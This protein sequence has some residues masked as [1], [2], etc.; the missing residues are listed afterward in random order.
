MLCLLLVLVASGRAQAERLPIKSFTTVN[1][2][3]HDRVRRI[4]RDSRGFLWFCTLEGLSRFDGYRFTNYDIKDG[5]PINSCQDLL[6][7]RQGEYWVATDRGV[8]RFNPLASPGPE[9]GQGATTSRFT[10]YPLSEDLVSNHANNLYEDSAGRIWACSV[11]GLF[12]MDRAQGK[13]AFER[14]MLDIPVVLSRTRAVQDVLEDQEGSLWIITDFGLHRRL[15][16]GR[17]VRYQDFYPGA[18]MMD[19]N[20]ALWMSTFGELFLFRPTPAAGYAAGDPSPW[21]VLREHRSSVWRDASLPFSPAQGEAIR[22]STTEGFI[23]GSIRALRQSADGSIWFGQDNRDSGGIFHFSGKRFTSY[24]TDKGLSNNVI[25]SLDEDHAGNLWIGTYSNGAMKLSRN[26]FLTF[27]DPARLNQMW[28]NSIFEDSS[29]NFYAVTYRYFVNRLENDNFVAQQPGIPDLAKNVGWGWHHGMLQDHLGEWWVNTLI[30]LYRFPRVKRI[31]ELAKLSPKAFY[32]SKNG[33]PDDNIFTLFED[34]RGDIWI[35]TFV[36][37]ESRLVRWERATEQFHRYTVA[38]GLPPQNSPY[39]FCEDGSGN[40][41]IGFFEGGIARYQG[42]RFTFFGEAEGVPGGAIAGL[43]V[44]RLKGLW[45]AS[46]QGG[47]S[48]MADPN[49]EQM[50]LQTYTVADGLA[51]NNIRCITEDQWGR[52]YVGVGSGVDRLDPASGSVTHYTT[53]DG[54]ASSFVTTAYRDR[55]NRLWFGTL[56]GLSMLVPS[57]EQL[58]SSLP[59]LINGLRVAGVTFPVSDLGEVAVSPQEFTAAQNQIEIDFF[60]LSLVTGE[61]LRYQFKLEGSDED[62]KPLTEQR[63]VNY[64]SLSPGSYRFVVRAVNG[65]GV[66]SQSPASFGFRILPPFWRRWW[67]VTLIATLVAASIFAIDRYREGRLRAIKESEDRFRTLAETASDA[68]ITIDAQSHIIFVNPAAEKVFGYPISEMLGRELT[69]LMPEY[70]RHLHRDGFNRYQE[71]GKRHLLWE[72]IELP[73]LHKSGREIPLEISFG[74]FTRNEQRFFTGVARDITERKRAEEALQR[75]R[76]E[77]L[78][79]IEQVRKRIATD[80]HDDIGS[81]LTQISILSEVARRGLAADD[82]TQRK[83]LSM[84]ASASRELVD[85]MSD[86]VWA[87]N[88]QKDHLSDLTQRMRLFAS[89]IFTG[90]DIRFRFSAPGTEQDVRIGANLRREVFLIFKE[91]VNNLVRHSGCREAEIEFRIEDDWLTLQVRDNG[92]GFDLSQQN[93][94]HGLMSMRQR[95]QD[96]GGDFEVLTAPGKGTTVNLKLPFN[97]SGLPEN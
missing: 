15:P 6:E 44:D 19:K 88:P 62:W 17:I 45:I 38:D 31:E 86:I 80:L 58:P 81:S 51:S 59:T 10:L 57:T 14:V 93:D 36:G 12:C 37:A 3:A 21:Q 33:L 52:I 18:M 25:T 65:D 13:E 40:L 97:A 71:T 2:L 50:Q 24:N 5:L 8:C 64:A 20:G 48:R 54:L 39:R 28:T 69:M 92:E 74:E 67:F 77:R 70:L 87:I 43:Y 63:T 90:G 78:A 34:S 22:F 75:S 73:G 16:D 84:I 61:A 82:A 85:S 9:T 11:G 53:S 1:G 4:V 72:A 35:S 56:Q 83:P 66:V 89:D 7:T 76:E 55:L 91:S 96:S 29:G 94:G 49:A 23:P 68:I 42:G 95:A 26:G 47:L 46:A 30:G 27:V 32:S 41:W 60:G 79:E